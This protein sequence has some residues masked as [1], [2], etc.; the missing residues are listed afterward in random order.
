MLTENLPI[1]RNS[2]PRIHA[3][4]STHRRRETGAIVARP[5]IDDRR[6]SSRQLKRN[7]I[8][9]MIVL[10]WRTGLTWPR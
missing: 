6:I 2:Q 3:I 4:D 8:P 7:M 5:L 9:K 10:K 1:R